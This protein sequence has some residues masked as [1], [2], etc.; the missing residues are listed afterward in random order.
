MTPY[1]HTSY[2]PFCEKAPASVTNIIIH[3]DVD[4]TTTF[5]DR[6]F[7]LLGPRIVNLSLEC[8]VGH[9][10]QLSDVLVIFPNLLRLSVRPCFITRD[11][12]DGMGQKHPLQL[13]TISFETLWVLCQQDFMACLKQLLYHDC[14]YNIRSLLL[15]DKLAGG[16]WESFLQDFSPQLAWRF[17]DISDCLRQRN[18]ASAGLIEN[19][20]W[21]LARG[22]DNYDTICEFTEENL[23]EIIENHK[24][25][26]S[27]GESI[28]ELEEGMKLLAI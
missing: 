15:S 4:M 16:R 3:N 7:G 28:I 12:L 26:R 14:L 22:D 17:S 13:L 2:D 11:A 27:V 21:I 24:E 1:L 18:N 8:R 10:G 19:G 20:V 23:E 25:L 5:L 6:V 9:W